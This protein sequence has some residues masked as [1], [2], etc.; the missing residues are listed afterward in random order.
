MS[1]RIGILTGGGDAP[2]LNGI[3]EACSRSLIQSGY[4]VFGIQDGFEGV[5]KND[6]MKITPEI[7]LGIHAEAGT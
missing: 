5:F 6:V 7:I 4:S 3:I 2:G 1:K